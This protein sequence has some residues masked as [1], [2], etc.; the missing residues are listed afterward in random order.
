MRG[1]GSAKA[2]TMEAVKP[3]KRKRLAYAKIRRRPV[4]SNKES[5]ILLKRPELSLLKRKYPVTPPRAT[6]GR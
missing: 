5:K 1:K 6:T 2:V 4:T 3:G